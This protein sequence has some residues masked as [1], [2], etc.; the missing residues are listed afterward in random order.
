MIVLWFVVIHYLLF[1]QRYIFYG[2]KRHVRVKFLTRGACDIVFIMF[3]TANLVKICRVTFT[4]S[5]IF[6]RPTNIFPTLALHI[7]LTFRA[8]WHVGNQTPKPGTYRY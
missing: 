5:T 7:I 6:I 4:K 3:V 8:L 1:A 2:V